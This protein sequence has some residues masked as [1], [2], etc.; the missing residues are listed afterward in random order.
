MKPLP[1]PGEVFTVQYPFIRDKTTV[2]AAHYEPGDEVCG[3]RVEIDTWIP[4][5]RREYGYTGDTE[6]FADGLGACVLTV[7]SVHKPGKY[8]TRFFYTRKWITPE[9]KTFG[10]TQLRIATVAKFRRLAAGYWHDYR[11]KPQ[12]VE[13][14]A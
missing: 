5:V 4:G 6:S 8:P 7:V 13:V 1:A 11:I 3:G 12:P 9:H 14:P 2:M 10:K